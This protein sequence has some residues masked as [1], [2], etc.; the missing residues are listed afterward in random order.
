M[1]NMKET[2]IPSVIGVFGT[3]LKSLEKGLER[4]KFV[5]RI[6]QNSEKSP[7]NLRS[8]VTQ[9]PVNI[10]DHQVTLA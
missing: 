5:G 7:R 4:L 2:V 8:S 1:W 6:D 3:V 10:K 9:T